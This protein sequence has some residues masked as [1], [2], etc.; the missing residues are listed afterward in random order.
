MG[1]RVD[2]GPV[3]LAVGDGTTINQTRISV[4][5]QHIDRYKPESAFACYLV[6]PQ[7]VICGIQFAV[8]LVVS[9]K[10]A[11]ED[12]ASQPAHGLN[13]QFAEGCWSEP[14]REKPRQAAATWTGAALEPR[15]S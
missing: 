8:F 9:A 11:L 15:L 13:G 3:H 12:Q 4:I 7:E 1:L 6:R 2:A 10:L 5:P 14:H